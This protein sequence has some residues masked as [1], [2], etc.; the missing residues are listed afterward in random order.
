MKKTLQLFILLFS[1]F[2]FSQYEMIDKKMDDMPKQ[3]ENSITAIADYINQ[4]FTS[5]EDKIRAAFY[6]TTS[7]ISYDVASMYK[8]KIQTTEE[9]INSALKTKKGVCMH[10]AEVFNA[11]VN[12]MGMKSYVVDGYTKQ[13]GKI[14]RLSHSWNVCTI[15]GK[16]YLFDPT[17]GSGYVNEEVFYKKQN[18]AYFKPSAADFLKTHMPFDYMWQLNEKPIAN[19]DFYNDITESVDSSTSYDFAA[20][21]NE[22]ETLSEPDKMS[23]QLER[24]EKTGL[25]NDFI[26]E[27]YN[28]LKRIWKGIKTTAV[29]QNYS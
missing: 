3:Y 12:Q 15:N 7:T 23:K 24:M 25:K 21:I 14:A 13:F 22:F 11:I 16:W 17:W 18:D 20:A 4:N 9:K 26:K 28:A 8:P 5:E 1:N 27:K 29:F 10:Y 2:L 19:D 6:W